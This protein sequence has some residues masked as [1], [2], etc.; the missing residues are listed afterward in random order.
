MC[1]KPPEFRRCRLSA[2]TK[3]NRVRCNACLDNLTPP[4]NPAQ[5]VMVGGDYHI[6]II[7]FLT[8]S[9]QTHFAQCGTSHFGHS[10]IHRHAMLMEKMTPRRRPSPPYKDTKS[11]TRKKHIIHISISQFHAGLCAHGTWERR[12]LEIHTHIHPHLSHNRTRA[13]GIHACD[14]YIGRSRSACV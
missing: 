11:N 4:A 1:R 10:C 6:T 7:V 12:E 14:T 9:T 5:R 3:R 2:T 8:L 13:H